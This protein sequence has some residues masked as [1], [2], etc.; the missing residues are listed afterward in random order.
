VFK[1]IGA[2]IGFFFLG[3]NFFGAFIGFLIGSLIDNYANI[4]GQIKAKGG[5]AE[6]VFAYYKQHSS[7]GSGDFANMLIALSAA[8]MRADGKVIKAELD[9]VKSFFSQQFGPQF[10]VAH[11]QTL[12][13]YV[14]GGEIPLEQ[15][16]SDI[17]LRT[18][19]EVRIQLMHYLFGIA[20]ADGHVADVELQILRRI[21][22]L[23]DIP[24]ADFE[25]VKNMFYRDVNS[26]Y[27][28][29]GIESNATEEEIKKAYRQM[30]IRYHPDKVA[31]MGDEYQKGAQEKFQKIQEAYENIKKQRGMN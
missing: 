8:V 25:S 2:A 6:D 26:D 11:L 18:Q 28:V 15:I 14:N 16:C 3:K 23:M 7:A 29:L 19:V 12:K 21:A 4:S 27:T 10:S 24:N 1:F 20:K 13:Q 22:N 31:A 5:S 30:A 9:Y 17:R